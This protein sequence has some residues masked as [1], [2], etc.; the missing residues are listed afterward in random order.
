MAWKQLRIA[1]KNKAKRMSQDAETVIEFYQ[2]NWDLLI[3][4]MKN[5]EQ[6]D[7]DEL[8]EHFDNAVD[9]RE[10]GELMV[11]GNWDNFKDRVI[12]LDDEEQEQFKKAVDEAEIF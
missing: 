11:A 12:Q 6:Q 7:I 8:Q 4:S 3:E 9:G 10:L 2:D 1:P 5:F